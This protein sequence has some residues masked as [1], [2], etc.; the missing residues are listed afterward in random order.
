MGIAAIT[1]D[2]WDTL[3]VDDS[4]EPAR[5][6]QGLDPKPVARRAMVVDELTKHHPAV[7]RA[8]ASAAWDQPRRVRSSFSLWEKSFVRAAGYLV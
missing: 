2:F 3:A 7:T 8:E 5:A 1:F 6:E 4:D